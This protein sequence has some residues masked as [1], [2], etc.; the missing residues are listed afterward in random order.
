M[1]STLLQRSVKQVHI[2]MKV[3]K[4]LKNSFPPEILVNPPAIILKVFLSKEWFLLFSFI[5]KQTCSPSRQ[6]KF[7]YLFNIRYSLMFSYNISTITWFI[8]FPQY[9]DSDLSLLLPLKEVEVISF[10]SLYKYYVR[11]MWY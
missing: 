4:T 11:S 1:P 8:T 5:F 6:K 2:V 3:Y 9:I 10:D 7:H